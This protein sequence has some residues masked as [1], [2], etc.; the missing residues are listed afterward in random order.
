V[1]ERERC[2]CLTKQPPHEWNNHFM[3]QLHNHCI[4]C[5]CHATHNNFL[6][7]CTY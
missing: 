2:C 5:Y 6:I 1:E 7:M 3:M 4:S